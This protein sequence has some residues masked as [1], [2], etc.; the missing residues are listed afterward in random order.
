MNLSVLFQSNVMVNLQKRLWDSMQVWY[1]INQHLTI[2][3]PH[4]RP[5]SLSCSYQVIPS[6][7]I[8]TLQTS[9]GVDGLHS[10]SPW[11]WC[12]PCRALP[13]QLPPS[14]LPSS[15]LTPTAPCYISCSSMRSLS[16]GETLTGA[17]SA[18]ISSLWLLIRWVKK[19]CCTISP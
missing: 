11:S 17:G 8:P 2:H 10:T 19:T 15:T 7:L 18:W 1:V 5:I 13:V 4:H 3:L 9:S 6:F 12:Q 16:W 14:H